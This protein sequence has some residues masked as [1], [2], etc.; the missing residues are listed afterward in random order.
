[1]KIINRT[2]FLLLIFVNIFFINGYAQNSIIEDIDSTLLKKYI[3]LA[4]QNYPRKL[5]FDERAKRAKSIVTTAKVSWLDPFFAGFYYRPE[6]G[7][8]GVAGGGTLTQLY[9][10]NGFQFGINV[11]LGTLLS[12]P[13]LIKT[14]KSDY[15]AAKAESDEYKITLTTE[16]KGRYYDYLLTKRQLELRNLS[17]QSLKALSSDSKAKYER[18]EITLDTYTAS[19][20][21][22][23]ESE[24]QLLTAEDAYLKAK[25]SLESIIGMR[26]E[27]VR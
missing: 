1:M 6:N 2:T 20:N 21:A 10:N 19:K 7:G 25:S 8:I 5:A 13:S 15:K 17:A 3:S 11:S 16:V 27:D 14:A 22:A 4:L 24:V 9:T 23:T 26:L 18:A 12:K